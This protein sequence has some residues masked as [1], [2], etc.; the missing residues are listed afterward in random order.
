MATFA[1]EEEEGLGGGCVLELQHQQPCTDTSLERHRLGVAWWG[2]HLVTRYVV[3]LEARTHMWLRLTHPH[4]Y[5]HCSS[6]QIETQPRRCSTRLEWHA[7][8]MVCG[9]RLVWAVRWRVARMVSRAASSLV[10]TLAAPPAGR[11]MRVLQRQATA[12]LAPVMT[13]ILTS[14][15]RSKNLLATMWAVLALSVATVVAV[16]PLSMVMAQTVPAVTLGLAVPF[17]G[18]V[19]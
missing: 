6:C 5:T 17:P 13:Q 8:A 3:C 2:N 1:G 19:P 9:R 15:G 16:M 14:L 10:M 12:V 4:N 7:T 18:A 11:A